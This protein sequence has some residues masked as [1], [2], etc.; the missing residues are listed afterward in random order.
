M[1]APFRLRFYKW[2]LLFAVEFSGCQSMCDNRVERWMAGVGDEFHSGSGSATGGRRSQKWVQERTKES[3]E[4]VG[5]DFAANF[6]IFFV[7]FRAVFDCEVAQNKSTTNESIAFEA[8][9]EI[10]SKTF[11]MQLITGHV[12]WYNRKLHNSLSASRF[13]S[14][15]MNVNWGQKWRPL[16]DESPPFVN[17]AREKCASLETGA[18]DIVHSH[19]GF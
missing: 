15:T 9:G 4:T 13:F 7:L 10:L 14:V 11:S 19:R 12:T 2:D 16:S 8:T 18:L 5:S 3:H 17:E 1:V 6:S